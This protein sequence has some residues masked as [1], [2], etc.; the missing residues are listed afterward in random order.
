MVRG[1]SVAHGVVVE[2][3]VGGTAVLCELGGG[4]HGGSEGF[5]R[6]A[7]HE[8]SDRV[9]KADR[10]GGS[11]EDDLVEPGGLGKGDDAPWGCEDLVKVHGSGG[12][13]ISIGDSVPAVSSCA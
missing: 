3:L 7:V 13:A 1:I 4:E 11:V 10:V 9:L 6:V 12:G 8:S 5:E 2:D